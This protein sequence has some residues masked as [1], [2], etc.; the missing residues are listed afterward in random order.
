MADL[1]SKILTLPD[2]L[3]ERR[4]LREEGKTVVFTNGCFDIIHSGHVSYLAF[5]RAQGYSEEKS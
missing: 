1:T 2:L 4:R 5:A 3:A